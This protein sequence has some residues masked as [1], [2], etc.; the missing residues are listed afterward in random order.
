MAH[1]FH[2]IRTVRTYCRKT[3]IR[4]TTSSNEKQIQ[5]LSISFCVFDTVAIRMRRE[6]I[7]K[8]YNGRRSCVSVRACVSAC[9]HVRVRVRARVS[10]SVCLCACVWLCACAQCVCAC[11]CVGFFV[12]LRVTLCVCV[13]ACTFAFLQDLHRV[14][15]FQR[16]A[17]LNGPSEA[18]QH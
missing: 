9:L 11:I 16:E 18:G 1:S 13:H 6:R 8:Q 7:R 2:N 15:D 17:M 3:T 14:S 12:H 10:L 5:S 4:T